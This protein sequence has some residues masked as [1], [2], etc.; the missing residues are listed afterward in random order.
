M[1]ITAARGA[2]AW[3]VRRSAPLLLAV[4]TAGMITGGAAWLA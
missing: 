4:T 3:L 1:T 2:R